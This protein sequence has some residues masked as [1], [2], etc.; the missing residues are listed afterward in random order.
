MMTTATTPPNMMMYKFEEG[1]LVCIRSRT[2][3][4]I[5][6]VM[7]HSDD[8]IIS[9]AWLVS[10]ATGMVVR[11]VERVTSADEV[12][13]VYYDFIQQKRFIILAKCLAPL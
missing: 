5:V 6:K 12:R 3:D 1:D 7:V 8:D 2:R 11:Y 4:G 10:G 13:V 9:F